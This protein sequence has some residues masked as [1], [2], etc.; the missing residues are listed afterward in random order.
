VPTTHQ[1]AVVLVPPVEAWE[2]IQAIR[3]DHDR[4]FRRWM[5]HVTLLYPFLPR[6]ELD[7]AL[8]I[9]QEALAAIPPFELTLPRLDA[10][11]HRCGT[12]TLWLAPEPKEALVT[13]QRALVRA[14]PACDAVNRFASGFTPHL[15]VGQ[16]RGD[17]AL[18]ALR[19]SLEP[20]TPIAFAARQVTIIVR[21]PPPRD[22]FRTFAEVPLGRRAGK[23]APGVAPPAE[24]RRGAPVRP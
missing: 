8:P 1:S 17:E 15:S 11:R 5:P 14:L 24:R 21:D 6:S 16:A 3:R 2:R 7:G 4:Q 19:A 9:A 22:V 10:F 20:W 13:V 18:R 23:P 12:S